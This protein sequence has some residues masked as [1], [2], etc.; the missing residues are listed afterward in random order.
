MRL[1]AFLALRCGTRLMPR[2]ATERLRSDALLLR[3]TPFGEADDIV[4]LFTE[5]AGAVAGIARG[6]R[7]SKRRFAA[8]EPMHVL[9]ITMEV[10]PNR[11]LGRLTE[12]V[13]AR[14]RIGLTSR[15]ETMNAAGRALRWLRR[16]A[17][18][19]AAEPRLWAEINGLLD[20]L[21]ALAEGTAAPVLAGAGLRLLVLLGWGLDL[22]GCVRCG[23]RCP[24]NARTMVDVAAGGV[25][26]RDCGGFGHWL[27]SRQRRAMIDALHGADVDGATD[28]AI[29]LIERALEVHGRGDAT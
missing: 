17:P 27:T 11:E 10:S 12:T 28:S 29:T 26:C 13:L 7:R 5:R 2:L 18:Q 8:L 23:K 14:P 19:R 25:V 3:R 21:D 9:R 6:A 16:A 24:D 15:L 1:D 4:H 22:E 20:R